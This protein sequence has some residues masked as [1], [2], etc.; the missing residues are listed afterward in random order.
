M[1]EDSN[2]PPA[3]GGEVYLE[4]GEE[5]I[6]PTTQFIDIICNAPPHT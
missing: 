3:K 4:L 5:D 2:K 1:E 6:P